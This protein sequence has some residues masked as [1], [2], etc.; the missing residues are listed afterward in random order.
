LAVVVVV[1]AARVQPIQEAALAVLYKPV[2]ELGIRVLLELIL[3]AAL[4][5]LVRLRQLDTAV[6]AVLAA[7]G[8]LPVVE[9]AVMTR[10]LVST[11]REHPVAAGLARA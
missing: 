11:N 6:L 9:A 2:V 8:G 5:V 3:L 10:V 1:E 7:H 4:A